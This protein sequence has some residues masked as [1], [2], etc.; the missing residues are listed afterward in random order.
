MSKTPEG[1][2]AYP[3]DHIQ[4]DTFKNAQK[5]AVENEEF[6]NLLTLKLDWGKARP[7][8]SASVGLFYL[9][10]GGRWIPSYK[11]EV[12]G[13]SNAVLKLQTTPVNEQTDLEDVAMK[14]FIA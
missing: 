12:D 10:K 1:V 7:A 13:K 9:Q 11:I 3:I 14:L 4:E 8:Q 5:P 2:K 6:R